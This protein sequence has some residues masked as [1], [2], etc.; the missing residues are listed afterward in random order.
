MTALNDVTEAFIDWLEPLTAT[1]ITGEY[2][3]ITY[4]WEVDT[5]TV[6]NFTGVVQNATPEDLQVL[7]EGNRSDETIK[8]HTTTKLI[9]MVGDSIP[10]DIVSYDGFDW[11]VYNLADRRIGGYYKAILVKRVS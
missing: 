10:G 4:E 7:P 8:I 5:T 9:A 1:R 6:I 3:N 2:S 11:M